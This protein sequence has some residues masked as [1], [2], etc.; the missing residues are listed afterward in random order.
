MAASSKQDAER[1]AELARNL[2]NILTALAFPCRRTAWQSVDLEAWKAAS[3]PEMLTRLQHRIGQVLPHFS[4]MT[5]AVRPADCPGF[6]VA[7]RA[8]ALGEAIQRD[9]TFALRSSSLKQQAAA[10]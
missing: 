5:P 7:P 1:A 9:W 10:S 4:P 2:E 3:V 6:T 8:Q